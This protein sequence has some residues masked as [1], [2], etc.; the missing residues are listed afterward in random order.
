MTSGPERHD[1]T[2]PAD[3][4]M[5]AT[6]RVWVAEAGRTL[7]LGEAAIEDLRLLASELFAN[8]VTAGTDRL[9]LTLSGD[10]DGWVLGVD[11]V[12][13][14]GADDLGGLPIGRLDLLRALAHVEVGPDGTVRCTG[15]AT[16]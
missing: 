10:G 14:L 12:G 16:D 3:P 9:T 13:P 7:G 2:V 4:V 5:G 1:L 11:G 15:S 6:I 8:G